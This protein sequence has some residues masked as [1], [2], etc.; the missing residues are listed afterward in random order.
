MICTACR[1]RYNT[2]HA[3]LC[4]EPISAAADEA[5]KA[6]VR[7]EHAPPGEVRVLWRLVL[8]RMDGKRV[9][10]G[11]LLRH[12][13]PS[14]LFPRAL[15]ALCCNSRSYRRSEI[16]RA[17]APHRTQE[18]SR[19]RGAQGIAV[20][21]ENHSSCMPRALPL[22][23]LRQ[24]T[25]WPPENRQTREG[26]KRGHESTRPHGHAGAC[27]RRERR[28]SSGAGARRHQP[29]AQARRVVSSHSLRHGAW[30]H[31]HPKEIYRFHRRGK[32][33]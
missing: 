21:H 25:G 30:G 14:A 2:P 5:P 9:L 3:T 27:R 24:D 12:G 29:A 8:E 13:S 15:P 11:G 26:K 10:I 17:P 7:R 18:S 33:T 31:G 6:S 20:A 32:E 16:A 23:P 1:G 19:C 22:T 28:K 4:F